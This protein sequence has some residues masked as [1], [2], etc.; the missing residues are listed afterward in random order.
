MKKLYLSPSIQSGNKYAVGNTNEKVQC[1]KIAARVKALFDRDYECETVLSTLS[2]SLEQRIAE[3]KSK[4]CGYYFPIHTNAGSSTA[5]GAVSF[6]YPGQT[7]GQNLANAIVKG[8][9]AV[10]PVKSNRASPVTSKTGWTVWLPVLT[11]P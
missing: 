1:E 10:C 2:F 4:G 8:L 5:S 11:K 9:N 7:A 6:F 3:A